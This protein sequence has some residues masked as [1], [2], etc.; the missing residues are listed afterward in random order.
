MRMLAGCHK[1]RI[2]RNMKTKLAGK[3]AEN[4]HVKLGQKQ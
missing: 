3:K 2:Q 4:K 1:K